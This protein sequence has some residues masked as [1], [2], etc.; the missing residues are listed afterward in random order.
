LYTGP[1]P[2]YTFVYNVYKNPLTPLIVKVDIVDTDVYNVDISAP[3]SGGDVS[4]TSQVRSTYCACIQVWLRMDAALEP[5]GPRLVRID[6]RRVLSLVLKGNVSPANGVLCDWALDRTHE[7][8]LT[9]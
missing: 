1:Y 6:V 8:P 9:E 2:V 5:L 4:N 7:V 3:N